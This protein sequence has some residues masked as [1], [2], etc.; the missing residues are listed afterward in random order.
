[1]AEAIAVYRSP[2]FSPLQHRTNDTA[3]LDETLACLGRCGWRVSQTSE[4]DV[5]AGHLPVGDLYLNMCQGPLASERLLPLE[6]DHVVVVNRPSSVLNCH[7]HRLVKVIANTP[8]AFPRTLIWSA[9][10]PLPAE[11]IDL[12]AAGQDR[13]WLKRGDVHA[14]RPEDVVAVTRQQLEPAMAAF[15]ERGVPWVALQQHVPGTIVK[16][17]G[18]AD[19][20]FFRWYASDAGAA[21]PRPAI[22]EDRL[23]ALAFDAAALLGL[24]VFGGDVALPRPNRPILIDINDWPSFAPFREEAAQAIAAYVMDRVAQRREPSD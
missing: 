24:E 20:R 16:F 11:E 17:Y 4:A 10:A 23:K 3:I 2:A 8:L 19:G 12:L 13:I 7:R 22:D 15:A 9:V 6:S 21:G 5:A 14:E 1:V 18:V